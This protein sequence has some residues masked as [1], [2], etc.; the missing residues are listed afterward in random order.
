MFSEL[1]GPDGVI[2]MTDMIREAAL[3]RRAEQ[4]EVIS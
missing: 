4:A 2:E 1:G 3:S